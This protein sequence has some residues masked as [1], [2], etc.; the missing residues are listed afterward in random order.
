MEPWETNWED[1]YEIL[2]IGE[3]STVGQIRDAY[4]YKAQILHPDHTQGLPE[5]TRLRSEEEFK[6]VNRAYDVLKEPGLRQR[7]DESFREH[8]SSTP[9]GGSGDPTPHEPNEETEFESGETTSPKEQSQRSP[10]SVSTGVAKED[11]KSQRVSKAAVLVLA[12]VV[13]VMVFALLL[14]FRGNSKD[15]TSSVAGASSAASAG[16]SSSGSNAPSGQAGVTGAALFKELKAAR[17]A[18]TPQGYG[19]VTYGEQAP[20]ATDKTNGVVGIVRIT[21]SGSTDALLLAVYGNAD[22]SAAG[23][24]N[25]SSIL[26]TG[27][28]RAFLP[29]LPDADCANGQGGSAC[30]IQSGLILVIAKSANLNGAAVLIEAGKVLADSLQAK[31]IVPTTTGNPTGSSGAAS[32]KLVTAS[33]AASAL[34]TS[35]VT[36]RVDLLGNCQYVSQ[37]S[38][39]DSVNL[40][41]DSG[42]PSKYDFDHNRISAAQDV[43]GIGDRAFIFVSQAPFVELHILK[44][45]NYVVVTIY[46]EGDSSLPAS[47]TALGKIVAKRM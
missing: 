40:L 3:D 31:D 44:G 43:S 22:Q 28:A 6:R 26:P 38:P 14:V 13:L 34:K 29:Y 11:F 23:M 41:I 45:N 21:F 7:Y 36:Q 42:G 18:K 24:Q 30:G 10:N 16:G 12:G 27:N 32:C 15:N 8:L 4:R 1:Y 33:E 37:Q 19:T 20:D 35:A 39:T 47:I 25:Y 17:F 9:P 2:G 46:N 5:S